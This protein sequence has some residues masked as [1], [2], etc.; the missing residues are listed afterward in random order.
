MLYTGMSDNKVL[1]FEFCCFSHS[2]SQHEQA[3]GV[4]EVVTDTLLLRGNYMR[5]KITP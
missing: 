3:F 5:T 1:G 4:I 2:L